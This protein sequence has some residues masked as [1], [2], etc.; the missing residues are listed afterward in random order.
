[1]NEDA[2]RRRFAELATRPVLREGPFYEMLRA[3]DE[4]A[5]VSMRFVKEWDEV[6]DPFLDRP[7]DY[8][9]GPVMSGDPRES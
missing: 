7:Y 8:A 3:V 1:V 5:G 9:H 4:P 6:S 2:V